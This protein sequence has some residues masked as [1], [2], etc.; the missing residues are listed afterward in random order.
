MKTQADMIFTKKVK[1]KKTVK[2]EKAVT[3]TEEQL[4]RQRPQFKTVGKID[5]DSIGKPK[6]A[7]VATPKETKPETESVKT[8]FS[9]RFWERSLSFS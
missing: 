6:P 9:G 7:P 5:L 1:E 2:V 3:K 4:E 8:K